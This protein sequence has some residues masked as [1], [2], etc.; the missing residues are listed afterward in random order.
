ME[1]A[2]SPSSFPALL[3]QHAKTKSR[4]AGRSS[5]R[6]STYLVRFLLP[7]RC[8]T[9]AT[10][11]TETSNTDAAT[12]LAMSEREVAVAI[13]AAQIALLERA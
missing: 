2:G 5:F 4:L 10:R 12:L 7:H 1:R 3:N 8:W 9:G 11:S 13:F 6:A